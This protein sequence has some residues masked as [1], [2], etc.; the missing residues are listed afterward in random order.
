MRRPRSGERSNAPRRGDVPCGRNWCRREVFPGIGASCSIELST[1]ALVEQIARFRTCR[2]PGMGAARRVATAGRRPRGGPRVSSGRSVERG[3]RGSPVSDR[4]PVGTPP[5]REAAGGNT[6]DGTDATRYRTPVGIRTGPRSGY[7]VDF[8]PVRPRSKVTSNCRFGVEDPG[9]NRR[10]ARFR[11]LPDRR[12]ARQCS[13]PGNS[14]S[15]GPLATPVRR[16]VRADA[17]GQI[18]FCRTHRRS[19]VERRGAGSSP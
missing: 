5:R 6:E 4:R 7:G 8:A 14:R 12:R 10:A 16:A 9:S 3:R 11:L 13:S 17:G 15:N 2:T 19:E 18:L 1:F